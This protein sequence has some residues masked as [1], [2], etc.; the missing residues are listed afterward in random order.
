MHTFIYNYWLIFI[1]HAYHSIQLLTDDRSTCNTL[2]ICLLILRT[3]VDKSLVIVCSTNICSSIST[4]CLKQQV[5]QS[6]NPSIYCSIATRLLRSNSAEGPSYPRISVRSDKF[7]EQSR[8]AK[9]FH[10]A[11]LLRVAVSTKSPF[12]NSQ[13]SS[14]LAVENPPDALVSTKPDTSCVGTQSSSRQSVRSGSPTQQV[15]STWYLYLEWL[16]QGLIAIPNLS[17]PPTRTKGQRYQVL[18]AWKAILCA[19]R[20]LEVQGQKGR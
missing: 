1:S 11:R 10:I 16:E 14:D 20:N 5:Q 3:T 18:R 7:V 15:R 13:T 17:N 9:L 8:S 19:K 12:G 6:C 4:D 2:F